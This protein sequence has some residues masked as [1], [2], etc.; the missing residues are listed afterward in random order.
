MFLEMFTK[1]QE[2][3]DYE[4]IRKER[5][6]LLIKTKKQS[7]KNQIKMIDAKEK[8]PENLEKQKEENEL[9][10][11]KDKEAKEEMKKN[12]TTEYKDN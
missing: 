5:N 3:K 4:I 1:T 11:E 9:E 10:I 7:H 12:F 2:I 6:D 8:S